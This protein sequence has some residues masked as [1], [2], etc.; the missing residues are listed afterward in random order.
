[1]DLILGS[2]SQ[3]RAWAEVHASRDAAGSFAA[4]FGAAW[5]KVMDLDRFDLIG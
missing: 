2:H 5:A 1:V 4:A 3:L